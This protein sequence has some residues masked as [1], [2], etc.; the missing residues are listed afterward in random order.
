MLRRRPITL[1]S[2]P[3]GTARHFITRVQVYC[4]TLNFL[5][6]K[7]I[8]TAINVFTSFRWKDTLANDSFPWDILNARNSFL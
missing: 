2:Q 7:T 1:L 8:I 6:A 3:E 5:A 4:S